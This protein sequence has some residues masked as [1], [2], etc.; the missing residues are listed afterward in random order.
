MGS[1]DLRTDVPHAARIYDY[2]LGGKD[3]FQADR[4]AAAVITKNVPTMPV[5][6]RANRNF[7]TRVAHY[8]AAEV[9]F[10]QFL[11]IGTGLP[12]SPNL[13]EVVQRVAPESRI[14]YVDNDPIVLVHARALLTSTPEGK[15]AYIDADLRDPDAIID[16]PQLRETL[17]LSQPVAL[18][19][20]AILHFIVDEDQTHRIIDRL[21][22][23]LASGS[24]LA[25][26]TTTTDSAPEEVARGHAA[27]R[28]QGI[29]VKARSRAEVERLFRGLNLVDPGVVLV[30]Q[31]HP[32]EAAR[33]LPDSHVH[34]YGGVA[35]KP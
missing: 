33:A 16:A 31:W 10:R 20:M 2:L 29:D 19:L 12:T 28:A 15:T 13:H 25:L 14:V 9:G 30:H 8:L 32:D 3:N 34:L 23:P 1:V 6:M 4:D 7:M 24:A 5:S 26:S 22:G 17:D 35:L 18:C 27:F 21:M 11:D